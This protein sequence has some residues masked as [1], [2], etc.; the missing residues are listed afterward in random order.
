M[1]TQQVQKPAAFHQ[2]SRLRGKVAQNQRDAALDQS[3]TQHVERIEA[4]R[5]NIDHVVQ[6]Q[7]DCFYALSAV[8]EFKQGFELSD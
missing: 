1:I 3:T 2:R 6:I 8:F 5:I 7:H 4:G